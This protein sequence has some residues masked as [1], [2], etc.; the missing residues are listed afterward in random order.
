MWWNFWVNSKK[1][2]IG[3]YWCCLSK[4]ILY[5]SV[6]LCVTDWIFFVYAALFVVDLN[7]LLEAKKMRMLIFA[8]TSTH[9]HVHITY[10]KDKS[11]HSTLFDVKSQKNWT[12]NDDFTAS[13]QWHKG[14][15]V[16]R[17]WNFKTICLIAICIWNYILFRGNKSP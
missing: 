2:N 15:H 4:W 10:R 14:I 7:I 16:C 8:T 3:R 9:T 5:A 6:N 17:K 13:N 1:Q 12:E 11:Q